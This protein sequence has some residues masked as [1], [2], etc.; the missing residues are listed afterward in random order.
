MRELSRKE[1]IIR[2]VLQTV[3][4]IGV[5]FG[6]LMAAGGVGTIDMLTEMHEP[7]TK[8][9]EIKSYTISCCGPVVSLICYYI[10]WYF[11]IWDDDEES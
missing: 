4:G 9:I 10:G 6:V 11:S 7:V 3:L 5:I 8:A 1:I 2:H